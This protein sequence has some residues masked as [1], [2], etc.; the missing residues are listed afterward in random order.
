V[1]FGNKGFT[2]VEALLGLSA[3]CLLASL[4]PIFFQVLNNI[5]HGNSRLHAME[6]EVFSNQIKKEIRMSQ[7][8]NPQVNKLFLTKDTD[9]ILYEQFGTNLRR[10]VN[11]SGNEILLQN[12]KSVRFESI[13]N[14]VIVE[15]ENSWKRKYSFTA[16]VFIDIG[17]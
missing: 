4:L 1:N 8:I 12:V 6:W 14:G 15:V 17:N 9:I 3:F 13:K 7:R 16:R 10:R 5:N 2:L 11:L